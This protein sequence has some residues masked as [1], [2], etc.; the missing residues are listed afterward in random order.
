MF[1]VLRIVLAAST[2]AIM[3]MV[4]TPTAGAE[5]PR[6]LVVGRQRQQTNADNAENV[7]GYP[8]TEDKLSASS[9]LRIE[10]GFRMGIIMASSLSIRSSISMIVGKRISMIIVMSPSMGLRRGKHVMHAL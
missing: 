7:A 2:N 6:L 4:H 9:H 5:M 3:L 8:A 1:V 10:M